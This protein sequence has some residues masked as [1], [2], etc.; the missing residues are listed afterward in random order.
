MMMASKSIKEALDKNQSNLYKNFSQSSWLSSENNVNQFFLWNTFFRRN[1]HTFVSIYLKVK[2]HWYQSILLFLM[3]K[4]RFIVIIA[5]RASAKSFLIAVYAVCKAILY[6]NSQIVLT[7]GTRGQSRLIVTEKIQGF[8][9]EK[10]FNLKREIAKIST[11]Q[12]EVKVVF[13]NGSTIETVTC[14]DN[15]LGHR[16]TVNVGEEAKTIDKSILDKVIKPFRIMRQSAFLM[17]DDYKDDPQFQ[18]N[19]TEIL[20]S[21]SIEES[22]WLYKQAK[23]AM[24]GM[25]SD[26]GAF[27][28]AMDYAITLKHNIRSREQ[29]CD[30]RK[31]MDGITWLVEYENAVLR[32]NTNAYFT[33]DLIKENQTLKRAFY[34]KKQEDARSKSKNKDNIQKQPGEIRVVACDVAFVNRDAN[35]NSVFSCL[36]LFEESVEC[37]DRVQ[38]EY[39]VQ[40]P[41]L[42]ADKGGELKKQAIRIRQLFEDF[43]A[44]YIVLDLR[45]A[46]VGIYDLLARVLYDDERDVEY[47]PLKAMNDDAYANRIINSS[48]QP[49]IYVV[50]ASSKLNSE[51]A[52]NL[53]SMFTEHKIELLVPKDDGIE[54]IVKY[55]PDYKGDA[56]SYNKYFYE[57]PYLETMFLINEL[58][59]LEYEKGENTGLIRIREQ[60]G[61]MKDRYSSLTMGCYFVS[62]LERDLLSKPQHMGEAEKLFTIRKPKLIQ[63]R[64]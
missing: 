23:I 4:C 51:M 17:L 56:D 53:R 36:R 39:R 33:Y 55:I 22:H 50:T 20:I 64:W 45:N 14:S 41:Y 12:N 1:P 62:Q 28:I 6:P 29:M 15:A 7:S 32:S 8:L 57:K 18:E 16:S 34:P 46:G 25:L 2:L 37:N 10:S 48:A 38:K 3:F 40:V 58:I 21:S 26:T 60:S 49:L 19:P 63:G 52:I 42:E 30:D 27:F 43:D 13:K 9:L 59:N 44:D 47:S 24:D 35:D 5:A 61:M 31:G 11:N 54:E